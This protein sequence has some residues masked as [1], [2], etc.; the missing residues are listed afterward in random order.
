[1]KYLVKFTPVLAFFFSSVLLA[2]VQ[3]QNSEPT[4]NAMLAS[5]PERLSLTFGNDVRLLKVTFSDSKG[6]EVNFGFKPVKNSGDNFSWGLPQLATG[7]YVVEMIFFGE[8]G[9]KM[10]ERINFMIH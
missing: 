2:H 3:L 1:M 8:D 6:E 10:K 4:N 7:N 9:H 5:S